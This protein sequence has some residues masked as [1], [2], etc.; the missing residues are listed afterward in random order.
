VTP[1]GYIFAMLPTTRLA[2]A[3][4]G[5]VAG[6]LSPATAQQLRG[7]PENRLH[8]Q[9]S[10]APIVREVAPSVVNVYGARHVPNAMRG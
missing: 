7:V 3:C 1:T 8:M 2:I 6:L 9:L 5:L 4:L 10:F